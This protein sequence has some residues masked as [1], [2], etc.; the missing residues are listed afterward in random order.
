MESEPKVTIIVPVHN[1]EKNIIKLIDSFIHL[2]YKNYKALLIID[3]N[4]KDHSEKIA[5]S[6]AGQNKK[7]KV[8]KNNKK[9]SAANRNRGV[10][11][12]DKN[13][14]YFAFTDSDCYVEK[15]WL[16][17]LV[18]A[19]EKSPKSIK[20]VGGINLT[21]KLDTGMAK[22]TGAIEQTILGG[23]N[24]AQTK[25][26]KKQ[27][28]VSSIPNCNALYRKEV[29]ENN[30]QDESLIT[31]QDGEFNYRIKEQGGEFLINP[32]AIVWHHRPKTLK[33]YLIRMYKYGR[34]TSK[35]LFKQKDKSKFIKSRWYGFLPP[36]FFSSLILGTLLNWVSPIFGYLTKIAI[37]IYFLAIIITTIQVVYI[38]K[39]P[40]SIISPIIIVLQHLAYSFGLIKEI[41]N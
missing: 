27:K 41:F 1:D 15:N 40:I 29:W 20:C 23:G 14:Q 11:E 7:I 5:E 8:I 38:I 37:S 39:K 16:K 6:L 36:L 13:T 12:A 35:I 31:G 2:N 28:K 3:K 21:P 18:E 30:K 10:L 24:T 4:S 9:G 17:N 32:K 26:F 25:I 22:L 34:A 33:K 19:I